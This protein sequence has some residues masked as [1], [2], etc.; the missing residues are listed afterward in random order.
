MSP[1]V[2]DKSAFTQGSL[3]KQVGLFIVTLG[4]YG[5]FWMYKTASQLD[6][7]T[8]AD[9]S[10]ILVI[11]PIYGQWMLSEGAEAV[12]DQSQVV[13]FLAFVAFGPVAWFLIQDGINDIASA[14]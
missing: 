14:A 6:R 7:G 10:P 2:T 4:L 8:D 5:L 1:Q 9:L 12:T 13:L 3:G 11:I